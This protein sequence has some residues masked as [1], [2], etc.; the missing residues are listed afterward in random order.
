MRKKDK[1]YTYTQ[2]R[3]TE[4][5]HKRNCSYTDYKSMRIKVD[6][7]KYFSLIYILGILCHEWHHSFHSQE[8]LPS[9]TDTRLDSRA[10]SLVITDGQMWAYMY[11]TPCNEWLRH[12]KWN[13]IDEI[14]FST[15]PIHLLIFVESKSQVH[16]CVLVFL[17]DHHSQI[18]QGGGGSFGAFFHKILL[19]KVP[20]PDESSKKHFHTM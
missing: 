18:T 12:V 4:W 6:Q 17:E 15:I 5:N 16:T 1:I 20:L 10:V 13:V 7:F 11:L 9:K 8:S 3:N 14:A 2:K 19:I